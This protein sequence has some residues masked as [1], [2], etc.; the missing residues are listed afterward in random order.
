MGGLITSWPIWLLAGVMAAGAGLLMLWRS[1][2]AARLAAV[3]P[4]D[5]ARAVYRRQ[6]DDLDDLVERGLLSPDE[7]DAARAEAARRLL[8]AGGAGAKA[9]TPG[10]RHLIL[11]VAGV[12][13][14]LALGLYLALGSPG[15]PDRPFRARLEQWRNTPVNRLRPDEAAAVLRDLAKTR[16]NDA[17][18]FA[19]LGQIERSS[20][21]VASAVRDLQH[22]ARL[23]PR[24]ADLQA[25]LA[26]ALAAAGG[27]KPTPEA[28]A[29]L[30]RALEIDPKN[31]QAQFFLGGAR[32]AQGNGA[33]AA[34]IWRKLASELDPRDVRR[35]QLLALADR[36]EKGPAAAPAPEPEIPA[37][38]ADFIKGMVASL[39]ARLD[40][41]PDNPAGWAQLVRSY[42]VLGDKPAEAAAL[43]RARALFAKE[44][45]KLAPIEAEAR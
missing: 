44:P 33:E 2:G 30:N 17:R 28:L 3:P 38:Q 45:A 6:L 41:Q 31:Q 24:N 9:E 35:P 11:L 18:L 42:R 7:Y 19:V 16:P 29:A 10:D 27:N 36:V 32:A 13:G 26:E 34:R 1:A 25:T 20:G 21:D 23:D 37:A 15:A 40:A 22:A 43:A 14:V 12:A 4:D 8:A 39:K 5:P